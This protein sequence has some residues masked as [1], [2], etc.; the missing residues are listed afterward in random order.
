MFM[1]DKTRLASFGQ[2][3][4]YNTAA[5]SRMKNLTFASLILYSLIWHSKL[6]SKH[7]NE[8]IFSLGKCPI[9]F[10]AFAYCKE[11]IKC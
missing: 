8:I 10:Y 9:S 5:T 2:I 7:L 1:W 4:V 3:A 11:N 6:K